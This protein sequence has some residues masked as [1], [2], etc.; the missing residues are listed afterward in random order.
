MNSREWIA[1]IRENGGR[2]GVFEKYR[3]S[4]NPIAKGGF[5]SIYVATRDGYKYAMKIPKMVDPDDTGSIELDQRVFGSFK[6]EM[7]RWS[8]ISNLIHSLGWSWS[9]RM[10]ASKICSG[11]IPLQ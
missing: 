8:L 7:D 10:R 1:N 5:S 11:P 9:W 3:L 6:E 4:D 2:L